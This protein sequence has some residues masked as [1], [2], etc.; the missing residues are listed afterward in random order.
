M[1]S[2]ASRAV[3]AGVIA[4]LAA[5][6]CRGPDPGPVPIS[7]SEI[8]THIRFLSDDFL[9]GRGLG[10][11][12]IALAADY[13]EDHFKIFG[14]EPAFG[15]SYRQTFELRAAEPDPRAALDVSGPAGTVTLRLFDDFV[16]GTERADAPLEVEG[17]LVYGGYLVQAPE[18]AW[19]DVKGHDYRGQ[20]ILCEVNE[21]G[22]APGGLFDGEDMTYYG[23]WPYKFEKASALGAAGVLIVHNPKGA[24]YGWE[25]VRNGWAVE[26]FFLHDRD[27][28]LL[29]QGWVNEAAAD[30]ILGL[31]GFKRRDLVA[32]AET[33]RF[34]PVPLGLRVKVRQRPAF[35]SVEGTNVGAFLRGRHK[36]A[37][38]QTVIIS[39]HYDHL[40]RDE[41][42]QGD[43]I[44][45]GAVDNSSATASMLALAAFFAQRPDDLK[46]DLLFAG[47]TAEE[48]LLLGSDYLARHLPLPASE[49]LANINFEMTNVWGETEDVFAIGAK[50]SDLDDICRRAAEAIGLRYTPDRAGRLGFFFR[51]D[52]LSFARAGIPG[53]WLHQGV[54]AKGPDKDRVQ[55]KFLDYQQTKYHK[56]TDEIQPDWDYAGTLQVIDWAREVIRLLAENPSPPRWKPESAF[57]RPAPY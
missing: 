10:S 37:R 7:A 29:F 35:R 31:A 18:R 23:R 40:G 54:V 39:A 45:N 36:E 27:P 20:V 26:R 52:Q 50:H 41:R 44:Y 15:S 21:P 14:L 53:V 32:K 17:E 9:E 56:V 43:Q 22:N 28:Q 13:Q 5:V 51:S 57:Q 47:V 8:E 42:L 46:I 55:R 19:D 2:F 3:L 4:A 24:A 11:R 38:N 12:G 30:A 34:A 49:V 16:V 1:K 6:C 33:E 25:V 48:H